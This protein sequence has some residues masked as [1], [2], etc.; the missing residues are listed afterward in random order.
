MIINQ[1]LLRWI[2]VFLILGPL[3]TGCGYRVLKPDSKNISPIL[4]SVN[5]FKNK[6]LYPELD[7]KVTDFVIM[8]LINWPWIKICQCDNPDYVLSGE[9][10][11]FKS[12]IPYTYDSA[13]NPL[14]YKLI[15]ET[16]FSCQRKGKGPLSSL[17]AD[18]E[19]QIKD[20]ER[21]LQIIPRLQEE[22][23]YYPGSYDLGDSKRAEREALERAIKR[24]TKRAMDQFMGTNMSCY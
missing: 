11:S 16:S 14:E 20:P 24:M 13:K 18:K 15:I 4:I 10:L 9:I 22:E 21:N 5:P 1:R 19:G 17:S 3:I 7:W 23:I 12:Q 8:E 2:S 6:T